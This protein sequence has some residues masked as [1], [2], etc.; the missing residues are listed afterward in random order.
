MPYHVM[1]DGAS[2]MRLGRFSIG[3]TRRGIGPCYEDKAARVGIRVQDLLD[4]KILVAKLEVALEAKNEILEKLYGMP[5]LDPAE[6]ADDTLRHAERLR[7]F[8][9]DTSLLIDEALRAGKRVLFE[10]AQGD[11]LDIDHGTYPFVTSSNPIAGAA[12]TGA[13]VGPTRIDHVL[14][15]SKAYVTRVGEGPFPT[16]LDDADGR[17]MMERGN[18]FGTTTGRQ[19]RCGWLDLVAL[20]YSVRLSGV[21]Q[22]ALTKLDV[23]SGLARVRICEAYRTREGGADHRLPLPPD[24]L[25]RLPAR[26]SGHARLGRGPLRVPLARPAAAPGPRLRGAHRRGPR[27]PDHAHRHGPGPPPGHRPGGDLGLVRGDLG[28]RRRQ[29]LRRVGRGRA[30]RLRH[31]RLGRRRRGSGLG[32]RDL[33]ARARRRRRRLRGGLL[34]TGVG[35]G[36]LRRGRQLGAVAGRRCGGRLLDGRLVGG[37]RRRG[38]G[39]S[40]AAAERPARRR[41]PRLSG[42]LAASGSGDATSADGVIA[43]GAGPMPGAGSVATGVVS[44]TAGSPRVGTSVSG[45]GTASTGS[46]SVTSR[47]RTRI[48]AAGASGSTARTSTYGR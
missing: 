3:T 28:G 37:R 29:G 25:P 23:L 35:V 31:G 34:G 39:A 4:P 9:A 32:R 48:V 10:G 1:L 44:R 17:H 30:H 24:G 8:I 38:R 22:L 27:G 19:R 41:A 7:P 14:G 13:G 6:V 45:S 18:E 21:S 16:E 11:M 5:R 42:S 43:T 15:V 33:G 36:L 47:Q 2:E 26:L 20:R 40:R 12:C 46:G